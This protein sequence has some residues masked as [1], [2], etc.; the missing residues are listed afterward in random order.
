MSSIR[1]VGRIREKS[2]A[3]S[4]VSSVSVPASAGRP[5]GA[6]KPAPREVEVKFRADGRAIEAVLSSPLLKGVTVGAA[7]ELASTY[8]DTPG[9]DLKR[10]GMTLRVRRKSRTI[11]LMGVKWDGGDDV[12]FARGEIEVRCPDGV[13]NLDL[14]E[15]VIRERLKAVVAGRPLAPIFET[16]F[17]RRTA[18]LR[19]GHSDIELALDEGAVVAGEANL[20]LAEVELE[21][22][23]GNLPDLFGCAASLVRDCGL[24]LQF[25]PKAGR[26]Y[27]LVASE[28]P[29]PQ[30]ATPLNISPT[31]TFDDLVA[32]VIA[33]AL[34]H[35]AA[36]WASLRESDAPESVHQL[37]V[38]L[39]RLRSA[40]GVFR[41]TLQLPELEDIRSEARRIASALGPARESDVFRAN[42][43]AGPFGDGPDRQRGARTLLDAVET[44]RHDSYVAVRRLIDDPQTSLFVLDVQSFIARRAWRTAVAPENLGLL[45]S[46]AKGYATEVLERLMRRALK[47]G[48]HLP[49]M[50]DEERHD[51]R[52]ALKNLRYAV[53]FF[54]GLFGKPRELRSYLRTVADLQED[55]GAHNDAVTAKAFIDSLCLPP[56]EE[57]HFASGYLLG[58]YRHA[59]LIADSHLAKKWKSFKRQDEFW[60]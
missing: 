42:A 33:N 40:L 44:R 5:Q 13:P 23:N 49:D 45:M 17:R 52:I 56:D 53:E 6:A 19:H 4:N 25:E 30:K 8:F 41:R 28:A 11:P 48:K 54:G 15:P 1:H 51:L 7:R 16:R 58:W 43:L 26:G 12:V 31:A 3:E 2:M 10:T 59:T 37:R 24:S 38:A 39:R 35:F 32:A 27:R 57:V 29:R 9:Q 14:F 21:L 22:K 20:P 18:L 34:G 55:L 50:P 60:K 36:N 46:E 47:R